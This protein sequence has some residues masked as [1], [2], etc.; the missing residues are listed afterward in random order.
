[1][2]PSRFIGL[3]ALAG[4]AFVVLLA[5]A[6][7]LAGAGIDREFPLPPPQ[8]GAERNGIVLRDGFFR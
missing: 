6:Y 7:L 4:I 2:L 8:E 5:W 1:V 3:F